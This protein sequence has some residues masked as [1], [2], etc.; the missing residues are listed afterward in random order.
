MIASMGLDPT[1][2]GTWEQSFG[3]RSAFKVIGVAALAILTL[4]ILLQVT[5]GV[6]TLLRGLRRGGGGTA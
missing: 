4:V 3:G 1:L 2:V 6:D 5:V